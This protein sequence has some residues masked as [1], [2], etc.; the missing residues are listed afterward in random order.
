M[1]RV[2]TKRFPVGEGCSFL[3]KQ[4][5]SVLGNSGVVRQPIIKGVVGKALKNSKK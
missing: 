2:I 4:L 1:D 3:I 5:A